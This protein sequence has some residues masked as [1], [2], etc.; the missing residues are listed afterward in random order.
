MFLAVLCN[1]KNGAYTHLPCNH[2]YAF[3]ITSFCCCT[4]S[5]IHVSFADSETFPPSRPF[6]A[7]VYY[8]ILAVPT[9][10]CFCII[11]C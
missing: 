9:R 6:R 4:Y 1:F 7:L 10:P 2:F 8:I 5:Q 3:A 11:V